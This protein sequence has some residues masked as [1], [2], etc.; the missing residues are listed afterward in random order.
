M[1][2]KRM[3]FVFIGIILILEIGCAKKDDFPVLTGPYLGQKPPG[4]V[5]EV[6]APAI[7]SKEFDELNSVFSPD[8]NAFY[9]SIKLPIDVQHTILSMNLTNNLW[10]KPAVLSFSGRF[11]DADPAFSCDGKKLFFISKRPL[12]GTGESEKDWDI[13]VVERTENDWGE[14]KNLGAP[15]NS[16]KME[17]YPSVARNGTIY[18]C[19]ARSGG[20]GGDDIYRS[21]FIGGKYTK[22]E[23]LGDMINTK[24]GEGDIFIAPDESY[25]IFSSGRPGGFGSGDLY[26]SYCRQ[27]GTWKT[28]INMGNH[29]NSPFLE[30]CPYVSSDGKYLFF[31]SYR[32]PNKN[33]VSNPLTYDEIIKTYQSPQNGLGDIYWIDAKIIKNLRQEILTN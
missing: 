27:D 16:D 1:K 20:L 33:Y 18:F 25:I 19:S 11:S 30:Y 2:C 22:P 4:M 28:S 21:R 13:W 8:G 7:I 23:N 17:I 12:P 24:Y 9:F 5:P 15:V 6:F 14:P 3:L 32:K 10:T 26:I 31:T 29:I